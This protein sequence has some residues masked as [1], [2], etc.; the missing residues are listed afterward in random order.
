MAFTFPKLYPILDASVIPREGRTEF[1]RRL[2]GD[3]AEAGV[4]LL[5]YRNKTGAEAELLAD[6]AVL[7]GALPAG[8]VKLILDDRADLVEQSGFDGVHVDAGDATPAEA[9]RLL[10]PE[11]IVGTYGGTEILLPGIL[12]EPADYFSIGPIGTTT[13]K[14]TAKVPIGA[15]GVRRLREQAGPEAVLVAAG[16]VT[17]E[18]APEVLAAGASAVAVSAAVFRAADPA[19]EF[20]RWMRALE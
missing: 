15:A 1:L 7:R 14:Q 11:R 3:L 13:T 16:G 20:R 12:K 9:R 18:L 4:T 6:A 17:L 19:A 2:G 5:E 10:G 8:K